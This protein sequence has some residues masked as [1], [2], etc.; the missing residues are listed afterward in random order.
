MASADW[1]LQIEILVPP[2]SLHAFLCDLHNFS[3]L[4]PLIESIEDLEATSEMPNA[5]RYKVTDRIPFGPFRFRTTYIAALE[6]ISTHEIQGHAWQSPGIRLQTT[7]ALHAISNGTRL[8]ESVCVR[9]PWML[10]RFVAT[11]ARR[12]HARMLAD[13]K[14]LL[15]RP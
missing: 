14:A 6:S 8:V 11:Q 3:A 9:A 12:A 2:D 4:H 5:R 1:T 7:Y 10:R 15:E 13:M